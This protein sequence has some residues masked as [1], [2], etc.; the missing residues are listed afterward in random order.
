MI[1]TNEKIIEILKRHPEGGQ[2]FFDALDL[3]IRSDEDLLGT[4]INWASKLIG[5]HPCCGCVLTGSFGRTLLYMYH[6]YLYQA[7]S[8]VILVNGGLREGKPVELPTPYI[9][10]KNF[11]LL[12]DSYY[13]GKTLH[14]IEEAL[15]ELN[16]TSKVT[17]A[18]VV[19]DGSRDN[20]DNVSALFRY[21]DYSS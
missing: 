8:E 7:F 15:Q 9:K 20:P 13:S 12:D 3:M 10:S 11:I 6:D 2:R 16:P 18:Y 4:Y 1:K 19:Y 5:T 14:A 21:Y 17:N